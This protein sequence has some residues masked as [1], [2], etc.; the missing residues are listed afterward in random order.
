MNL[1]NRTIFIRL[2]L[3]TARYIVQTG[4]ALIEKLYG[5]KYDPTRGTIDIEHPEAPAEAIWDNIN[6][7]NNDGYIDWLDA[8]GRLL[9]LIVVCYTQQLNATPE[10]GDIEFGIQDEG[11]DEELAALDALDPS[12]P[13]Q[14]DVDSLDDYYGSSPDSIIYGPRY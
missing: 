14:F 7:A 11:S 10:T 5:G 9:K 8:V 4:T 2:T 1:G 13:E 3:T 6:T 12:F